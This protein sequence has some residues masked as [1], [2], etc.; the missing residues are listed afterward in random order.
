[1]TYN[2]NETNDKKAEIS[3]KNIS[4][5]SDSCGSRHNLF[6]PICVRSHS[7]INRSHLKVHLEEVHRVH[8]RLLTEI[9]DNSIDS[10]SLDL[11][12]FTKEY[13]KFS[14]NDSINWQTTNF[15]K[16]GIQ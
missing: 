14:K 9:L 7:F 4:R 10:G 1:M 15:P 6:C 2:C 3:D 8:G 13:N 5:K 12:E 16:E 11:E